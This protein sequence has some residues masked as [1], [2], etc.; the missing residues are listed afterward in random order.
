MPPFFRN[1][2]DALDAFKKHGITHLNDLSVELM[3]EY[4]HNSF[5][6]AFWENLQGSSLLIP[7]D[8]Y[9]DQVSELPKIST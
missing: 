5:V 3:H 7:L 2:P 9:D 8:N 4:V 1:N 6:P